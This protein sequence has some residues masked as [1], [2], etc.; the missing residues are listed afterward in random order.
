MAVSRLWNHI[1]WHLIFFTLLLPKQPLK[2]KRP[3]VFNSVV[4]CLWKRMFWHLIFFTFFWPKWPLEAKRPKRSQNSRF[5]FMRTHILTPYLFHIFLVKTAETF[6]GSVGVGSFALK[7]RVFTNTH[8]H[9]RTG[10]SFSC[11]ILKFKDIFKT[12]LIAKTGSCNV[13]LR[14]PVLSWCWHTSFKMSQR[15][16]SRE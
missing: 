12:N 9:T 6:L 15:L 11:F 1:F 2:A 16:E 5:A 7:P 4:S 14:L 8:T 13:K 10:A 3:N